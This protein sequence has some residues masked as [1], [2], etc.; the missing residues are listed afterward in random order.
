MTVSWSYGLD[1]DSRERKISVFRK[2]ASVDLI[3][4]QIQCFFSFI[5]F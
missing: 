5:L 2:R 3:D 4:D 1:L